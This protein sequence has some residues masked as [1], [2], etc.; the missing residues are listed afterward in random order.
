MALGS[1]APT[2]YLELSGPYNS[3]LEG[4][5]SYGSW[6]D[7]SAT[8]PLNL[9][10]VQP[11]SKVKMMFSIS[12]RGF[13]LPAIRPYLSLEPWLN[14]TFSPPEI[15]IPPKE[16]VNVTATLEIGQNAPKGDYLLEL[17]G[18]LVS[19]NGRIDEC[20]YGRL[21]FILRIG[22]EKPPHALTLTYH[23]SRIISGNA[24]VQSF[25][26]AD[27]L[28]GLLVNLKGR[29]SSIELQF[30][31]TSEYPLPMYLNVR[32]ADA[33]N[34]NLNATMPYIYTDIRINGSDYSLFQVINSHNAVNLT[35]TLTKS[36]GKGLDYP[37]L[38]IV[39]ALHYSPAR[40]QLEITQ[41]PLFISTTVD[42][43]QNDT[44]DIGKTAIYLLTNI[45]NVT[46]TSTVTETV[47]KTSSTITTSIITS[48]TTTTVNQISKT[49]TQLE[50]TSIR[51]YAERD[52]NPLTYAWAIGATIAAV[53]LA[54]VL[55][56]K[57][58]RIN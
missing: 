45:P 16:R 56:M 35:L 53:I 42:T 5:V 13:G 14:I 44:T 9:Y 11:G 36:E 57:R 32:L 19:N 47:T 39:Q 34:Q 6:Q 48:T 28:S 52:A 10:V 43:K 58:R 8:S 50:E 17:G 37:S 4:F 12:N 38:F 25:S 24:S 30:K 51:A 23:S 40:Q 54:T 29:S 1:C 33:I 21:P 55:I 3:S 27:Q 22:A 7:S 31:I 26:E 20:L 15:S 18:Q 2:D 49:S 41:V 46:S